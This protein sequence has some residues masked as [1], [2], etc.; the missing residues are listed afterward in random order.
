[1]TFKPPTTPPLVPIIAKL[2][3]PFCV[4]MYI[5]IPIDTYLIKY[6]QTKSI[7]VTRHLSRV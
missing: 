1:M 6:S 3:C 2:S 7:F 5:L 4:Q